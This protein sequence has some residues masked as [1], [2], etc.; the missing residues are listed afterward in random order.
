VFGQA[1]RL[2]TAGFA[3]Q[4]AEAAVRGDPVQPR[5]ER[6]AVEP[7]DRTPCSQQGFLKHVLGVLDRSENPVTVRLKLAAAGIDELTEGLAV[8]G[9]G[10]GEGRLSHSGPVLSPGRLD[11]AS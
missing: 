4:V 8:A 2:R 9:L 5:P 3:A 6:A 11:N 7:A 1:S 10:T